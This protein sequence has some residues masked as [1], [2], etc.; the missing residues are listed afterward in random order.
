MRGNTGQKTPNPDTFHPV[1]DWRL[2]YQSECV[3]IRTKKTPH[4]DTFHD[5][6]FHKYFTVK[7]H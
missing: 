6:V 5:V 7:H 4:I 1:N 3:K 2:E